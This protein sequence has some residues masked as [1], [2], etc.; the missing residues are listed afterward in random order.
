MAQSV[1]IL[2]F[3]TSTFVCSVALLDTSRALEPIRLSHEM[4]PQQQT[5]RLIPM[6]KDLLMT[7]SLSF[8]ELDAVAFSCGPGSFT[9]IRIASSVAQAI[10]F[11]ANLPVIRISSLA[12]MAM[13]AHLEEGW[14]SFLVAEDARMSE[15][16]WAAYQINA[17]GEVELMGKEETIRPKNVTIVGDSTWCA[18]GDGWAAYEK[19]LVSRLGFK[20][21][22]I[23]ASQLPTANAVALLAKPVYASGGA[24]PA[25]LAL[26][27]YLR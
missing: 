3:D 2:A 25:S 24:V 21:R 7:S 8:R 13:A 17:E 10:G 4:A 15:V 26:P 22:L 5:K 19:A 14:S 6:I 20:P 11:G 23:K 16:Y 9:G 1:K 27:T 12:A 18:L